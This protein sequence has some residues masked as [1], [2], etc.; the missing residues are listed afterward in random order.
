MSGRFSFKSG[1]P[2]YKSGGAEFKSYINDVL[3]EMDKSEKNHRRE[4]A[5]FAAE[6]LR[7]GLAESARLHDMRIDARKLGAKIPGRPGMGYGHLYMG[8]DYYNGARAAYAGVFAPAHHAHLLEFG[9]K[10]SPAYPFMVRTFVEISDKLKQILS[11]T[12]A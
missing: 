4:A 9:T 12:I 6:A 1:R 2:K 11:A 5:K 3:K 7:T 8:I 10:K